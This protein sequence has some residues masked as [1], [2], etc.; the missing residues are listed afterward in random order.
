MASAVCLVRPELE[1]ELAVERAHANSAD[2]MTQEKFAS[3][4][5]VAFLPQEAI[6]NSPPSTPC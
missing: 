3:R 5:V 2:T 4:F 6:S 1:E